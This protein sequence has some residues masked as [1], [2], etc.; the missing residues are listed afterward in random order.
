M[1]RDPDAP[2]E[3]AQMNERTRCCHPER[4]EGPGGGASFIASSAP[5]GPS[6]TLGVTRH[7][8]A[9]T[10]VGSLVRLSTTE[11]YAVTRPVPAMTFTVIRPL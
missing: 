5:P 3:E 7:F 10:Y 1:D 11:P 2:D 6:L 9:G 8:C 4:S